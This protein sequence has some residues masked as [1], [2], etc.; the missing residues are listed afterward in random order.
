MHNRYLHFL[1][2]QLI[3]TEELTRLQQNQELRGRQVV[4][5]TQ[6]ITEL[7]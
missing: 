7:I 2:Q 1:I 3:V 6:V 5:L 4:Y